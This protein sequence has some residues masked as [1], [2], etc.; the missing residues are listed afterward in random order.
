MNFLRNLFVKYKLEKSF[1]K[2]ISTVHKYS[3]CLIENSFKCESDI[4]RT[5]NALN[6]NSR[7]SYWRTTWRSSY[8]E[9]KVSMES[10]VVSVKFSLNVHA[11]AFA[12]RHV[13]NQKNMFKYESFWCSDNQT[14][15]ERAYYK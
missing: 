13:G 15:E 3:R 7:E 1:K 2:D 12:R 5:L 8:I 14:P 4:R 6:S 10:K 11:E 9:R